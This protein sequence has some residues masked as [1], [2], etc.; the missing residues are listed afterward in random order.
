MFG[1][2]I[3]SF[4]D[5]GANPKLLVIQGTSQLCVSTSPVMLSLLLPTDLHPALQSW[6]WSMFGSVHVFGLLVG[7][8]L[9]IPTLALP[10]CQQ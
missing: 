8:S 10:K 2:S 7:A 9:S 5:V 4:G 1:A 6:L 3:P